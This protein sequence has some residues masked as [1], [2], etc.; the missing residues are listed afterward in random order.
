[1]PVEND[2]ENKRNATYVC[3]ESFKDSKTVFVFILARKLRQFYSFS[4]EE[5]DFS[6]EAILCFF[7]EMEYFQDKFPWHVSF[8]VHSNLKISIIHH[9][10]IKLGNSYVLDG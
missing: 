6:G 8:I 1:M 3:R 10:L 9:I 4:S 5:V 2:K 7:N